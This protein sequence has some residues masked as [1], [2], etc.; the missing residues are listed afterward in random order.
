MLGYGS[1]L[2]TYDPIVSIVELCGS[3]T[4]SRVLRLGVIEELRSRLDFDAFVWVLTD[5]ATEVG[6]A[7]L[8][9]VGD[10]VGELPR[11]IDLKYATL[12][13]R[14]TR[15]TSTVAGLDAETGGEL[16]RSVV[17]RDLLCRLGV[18]D[19]AS[20]VFRDR[21][22]CWAFL[23][24]WRR[25][26]TFSPGELDVLARHVH[27]ITVALRR[28]VLSTFAE[29]SPPPPPERPGP[30]A[31]VLSN[32]LVVRAQTAETERHLRALV[33]P[34]GDRSP[35]PAGAYNV[36]A[37]LRAN[38]RGLD[39]RP[40]V[41]RVHLSGTE[42]LTL[43]A[44]RIGDEIIVGIES[45]TPTDRGDLIARSAGLTARETDLFQRLASGGDTRALAR[46]M[47]VSEHTVQDH[48]K[49]VFAK[50]G[51]RTRREVVARVAGR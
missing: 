48:L 27:V 43:R 37:Q 34:D 28:C 10:A 50:T 4:D 42:W 32:D 49:A 8:A 7:P 6:A 19:V 17:W 13:N 30:I 29:P 14:W 45:T 25:G 35:I 38:E 41:A 39:D 21:F 23:D 47:G 44:A 26:S 46:D 33:P 5:P 2:G 18:R 51:T 9:D 16:D 12:V 20:V 31:L 11:L 1:R 15:L 40:P 36:A 22:G 3:A 24:L